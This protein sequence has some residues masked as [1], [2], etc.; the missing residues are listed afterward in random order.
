MGTYIPAG[1][2][3]E[4]AAKRAR[5]NAELALIGQI[6]DRLT[7]STDYPDPK[8][9][10]VDV[11]IRLIQINNRY[12]LALATLLASG[13]I[14]FNHDLLGFFHHTTASSGTF[15]EGWEPRCGRV[16]L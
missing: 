15:V 4:R 9:A 13:N 11:V 2:S 14:N 10:R 3:P 16:P 12:R 7:D 6:A 8:P 5:E 1:I